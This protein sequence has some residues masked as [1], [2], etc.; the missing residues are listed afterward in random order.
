MAQLDI[1][2]P[3]P[4]IKT[5][6]EAQELVNELW[7]VLRQ[8]EQLGKALSAAQAE[9]KQLKEEI[10]ALK[11]DSSNSSKP[12]SMDPPERRQQRRKKPKSSRQRGAQPGHSKH[13][14]ALVPECE[15]DGV[16]RFYPPGKCECGQQLDIATEPGV[17]HQVFDLPEVRFQVTEYQLYSGHCRHCRSKVT[18]RLPSWVPS[19][20]MGPGLLSWISVLAGQYHLSTRQIQSYL[21]AHWQLRFSVGAV[22]QAQGKVLPWL[23]PLYHQVGDYVREAHVGHA[24]ETTHYRGDERRRLWCLATPLAV[25]FLVHVSRG[26]IAAKQLLGQFSGVLVSDHCVGYG[27]YPRHRHQLCWAHVL[28][29]FERIARRSG[30]AGALGKHLVLMDQAVIRTRH[31]WDAGTLSES[32]YFR[33]MQR[34]RQSMQRLLAKGKSGSEST[35][36]TLCSAIIASKPKIHHSSLSYNGAPNGYNLTVNGEILWHPNQYLRHCL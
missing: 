19:G 17:R 3:P 29:N 18:T 16:E 7:P 28:R 14:R 21:Q 23:A 8:V 9:I 34:L 32:L 1:N 25:Y 36:T 13:E 35:R 30:E 24:D 2:S 6:G 31:R 33:R 12:P 26:K 27:D 10:E 22:S 11:L 15:V 5:L 4:Q 20:Q